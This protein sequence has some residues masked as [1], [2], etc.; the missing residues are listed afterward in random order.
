MVTEVPTEP[1]LIEPP[2]Q[3]ST[4]P[5]SQRQQEDDM[6]EDERLVTITEVKAAIQE[7]LHLHKAEFEAWA[8]AAEAEEAEFIPLALLEELAQN[9]A[10]SVGAMDDN[11][12]IPQARFLLQA[13]EASEGRVP[14]DCL[15]IQDWCSH[16]HGTA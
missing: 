15:E 16:H 8:E 9:M 2:E 5:I 1:T 3:S 4:G 11:L 6:N 13:F 7:W 12:Y 10:I 14:R